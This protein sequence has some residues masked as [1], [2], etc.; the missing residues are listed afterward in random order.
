VQRLA[1][2]IH[3]STRQACRRLFLGKA[4]CHDDES[5]LE[6]KIFGQN[7]EAILDVFLVIYR[8]VRPYDP[9]AC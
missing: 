6:K 5:L 4:I 7:S 3:G 2:A 8:L 9:K 1:L